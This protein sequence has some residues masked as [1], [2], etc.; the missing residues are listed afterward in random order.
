MK[1]GS[2][3]VVAMGIILAPRLFAGLCASTPC[4]A[5]VPEPSAIPEL[6]LCLTVTGGSFLLWRRNRRSL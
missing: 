5:A 3:L 2:V 1:I 4:P 6:V